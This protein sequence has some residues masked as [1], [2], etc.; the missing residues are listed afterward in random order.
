LELL[1]ALERQQ[2]A[3]VLPAEGISDRGSHPTPRSWAHLY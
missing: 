1:L 3:Q 2:L